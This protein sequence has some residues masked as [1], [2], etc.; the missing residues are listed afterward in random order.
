MRLLSFIV[1]SLFLL[2]CSGAE[3]G[4]GPDTAALARRLSG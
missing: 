3:N 1:L 4:N 2:P